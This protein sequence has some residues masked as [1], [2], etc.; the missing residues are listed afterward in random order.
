[1]G[2]QPSILAVFRV[3]IVM[4]I[5][6]SASAQASSSLEDCYNRAMR[7]ADESVTVG[8]VRSRCERETSGEV[9]GKQVNTGPVYEASALEERQAAIDGF[10]ERPFVLTP[11]KPELL[12]CDVCE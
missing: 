11:H 3:A 2:R 9:S 8:E 10:E 6:L 12:D 4:C 7:T 1:M 5:P